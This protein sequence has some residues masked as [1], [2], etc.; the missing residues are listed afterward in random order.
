[1]IYHITSR[2]AWE[3]AQTNGEYRA[4]SLT[5]EGF[6]H[7]STL[8]QILPVAHNFYKG[9]RGLIVLGIE[10]ALLS[11]DLKWEPPAGGAPPPGVPVGDQFPHIY[12]PINLNAVLKV[13][14]LE[15]N[16]DGT[17]SLP[18]F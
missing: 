6:I 10:P 7:S 5:T 18:T 11:S 13:A 2:K 15:S 4:D 9:E 8:V 1:M 17:F 16:E 12:G 3:E 14:D